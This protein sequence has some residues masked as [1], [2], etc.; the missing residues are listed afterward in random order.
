MASPRNFVGLD[1]GGTTMK[2]AVVNDDGTPLS[3]PVVLDTKPER[4]QEAGL[5]TM[6]ESIRQAVAAAKLSMN[7]IAAIGVATP[8]LMDIPAGLIL[9][10]PNLKPWRNVPVR[11]HIKDVFKK[12]TAFQND[13]N[14]ATYGEYWVG[15]GRG[16]KSLI[17]FTLGTGVGG[18][19][20]VD[21]RII[22]GHSSHGGELGH[23]RIDLP[24]HGRLCGCGR[25]GCLEA[26]ASATSIVQRG[27]EALASD[28]EPSKLREKLHDEDG[29]ALTAKEIFQVAAAGDELAMKIVDDTAYFLALG[30]TAC[31]A[32]VDPQMIVIGGG[33]ATAGEILLIKVREYVSRFGLTY[34]ASRVQITAAKLGSDAGFIGAAGCA[35]QI[36]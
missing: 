3:K 9:D 29:Q 28:R 5:E 22:E 10:P 13:A 2:A 11:D 18:G 30:C 20:I 21:D 15:A 27:R 26:Y 25:R 16:M 1:V 6:C 4:G 24:D 14:A 33:V 31:L 32:V 34:P 12:P 8:G 19:I 35:R 36:A 17:M 23:L 7:E